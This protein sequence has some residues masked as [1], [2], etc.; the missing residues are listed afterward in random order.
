MESD[1]TKM[2][3][4]NETKYG[5]FNLLLSM[6]MALRFYRHVVAKQTNN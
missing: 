1:N 6:I 4:I 2:K 3:E 5:K